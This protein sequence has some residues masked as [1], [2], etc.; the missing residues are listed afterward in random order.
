MPPIFTSSP[1]PIFKLQARDEGESSPPPPRAAL[2]CGVTVPCAAEPSVSFPSCCAPKLRAGK[3]CSPPLGKVCR[4]ESVRTAGDWIRPYSTQPT[5]AQEGKT[6]TWLFKEAPDSLAQETHTRSQCTHSLPARTASLLSTAS[7]QLPTPYCGSFC[8]HTRPL[9]SQN[10]WREGQ[11]GT[12]MALAS[13][14][15]VLVLAAAWAPCYGWTLP[16]PSPPEDVRV[17]LAPSTDSCSCS[18]LPLPAAVGTSREGESSKQRLGGG[19]SSTGPAG[20]IRLCLHSPVLC[21]T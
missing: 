15:F 6:G 8:A 5:S 7:G 13:F 14:L 3:G 9:D 21:H 1:S 16:P 11:R 4:T 18:P 19:L 17:P 2:A 12:G 10:G 20:V